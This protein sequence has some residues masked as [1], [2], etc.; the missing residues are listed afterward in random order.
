MISDFEI[1]RSLYVQ[2]FNKSQNPEIP[3]PLNQQ[4]KIGDDTHK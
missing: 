2:Q 3:K 4:L 1:L